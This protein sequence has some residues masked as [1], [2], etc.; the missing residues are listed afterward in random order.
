MRFASILPGVLAQ[1]S[2]LEGLGTQNH[3]VFNADLPKVCT[4]FSVPAR[5]R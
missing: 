4:T 3:F 5:A 2:Q 1:L